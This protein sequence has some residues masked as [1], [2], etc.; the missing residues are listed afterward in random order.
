[1]VVLGIDPGLATVGFGILQ[2]GGPGKLAHLR[3][4]A[5]TT[6]AGGKLE[7]RLRVIFEDVNELIAAFKPDH[8]A[9]EELY[10]GKN[11]TTG[12]PV[13]HARGVI[14]LAA[15]RA[16]VPVFVYRPT[17]V[18]QS[19][20]G[21]GKAEKR[22]VMEMTRHILGLEKLPRPDDAADALAIA[23]CHCNIHQMGL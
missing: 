12:L 16:G 9:I 23:L 6:K 20:V 15:A 21:Y 14:L 8:M 7:D 3:H 17:Q 18:K 2:T 4:G 1:M 13:A 19:V 10:F 5:V 22:Q 11:V